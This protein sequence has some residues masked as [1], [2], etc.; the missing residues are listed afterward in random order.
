MRLTSLALLVY[1]QEFDV[2]KLLRRKIYSISLQ[3]IKRTFPLN[4]IRHHVYISARLD[5]IS[6]D[7][8][9]KVATP[10][11]DPRD[12]YKIDDIESGE[13]IF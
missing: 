6:E 1:Y 11:Y 13:T 5:A 8:S 2:E 4:Y 9:R 3:T 12:N 10:T 7:N